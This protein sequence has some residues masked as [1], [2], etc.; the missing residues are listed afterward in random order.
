MEEKPVASGRSV[1][2]TFKLP[3]VDHRPVGPPSMGAGVDEISESGIVLRFGFQTE[4]LAGAFRSKGAKEAR[5][6]LSEICSVKLKTGWFNTRLTIEATSR[7]A[8]N[9][10]P[11]MEQ[12]RVVLKVP[13]WEREAARQAESLLAA[14]LAREEVEDPNT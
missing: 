8:T 3:Y 9:R 12:S 4:D 5:L 14:S 11:G 13:R 10:I 7:S 2:L 1:K 6:E